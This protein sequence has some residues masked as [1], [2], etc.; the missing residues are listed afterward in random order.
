MGGYE[1]SEVEDVTGCIPL[2]LD[3]C[4]VDG[5]IDLTVADLKDIYD[6]AVGFVHHVRRSTMEEPET[7]KWYGPTYLTLR[8]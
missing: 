2:L 1:R 7:W 4:V 6:N 8:T 5:K 3:K